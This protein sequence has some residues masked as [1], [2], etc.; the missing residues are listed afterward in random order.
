MFLI[1]NLFGFTV[2]L[3]KDMPTRSPL[4]RRQNPPPKTAPKTQEISTRPLFPR[5]WP[6]AL[7]KAACGATAE[8][9]SR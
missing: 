3:K 5:G 9:I 6:A 2:F 7:G 8:K 1:C 4:R